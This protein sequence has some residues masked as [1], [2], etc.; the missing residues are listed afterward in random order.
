M[1]DV[2]P[3]VDVGAGRTATR[4]ATG[5]YVSCAILDDGGLK[6]WGNGAFGALGLG[7]TEPRGDDPGEMGDALPYVDLGR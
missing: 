7:D 6:C 2:L 4:I 3:V 5:G 1:G